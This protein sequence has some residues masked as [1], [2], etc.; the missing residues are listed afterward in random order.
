MFV[1]NLYRQDLPVLG[2][3][4]QGTVVHNINREDDR[5]QFDRNGF[6]VR[7]A[8]IGDRRAHR[9][10]VTY[11]GINGDGHFGRWNISASTYAALGSETAR[12]TLSATAGHSRG[13]RRA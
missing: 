1:V 5:N 12:C 4:L 8:A 11:L 7:P 10:H 6:L 3:T 2:F 13:V 9:Y